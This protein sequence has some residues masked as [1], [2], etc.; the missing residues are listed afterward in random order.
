MGGRRDSSKFNSEGNYGNARVVVERKRKKERWFAS[1]EI[2]F[3]RWLWLDIIRGGT[4]R[5]KTRYRR[6][7]IFAGIVWKTV[8]GKYNVP[9]NIDLLRERESVRELRLCP[10]NRQNVA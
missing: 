4:A 9:V 6:N 7:V 10:G 2:S 5:G 3:A 8:K 1:F